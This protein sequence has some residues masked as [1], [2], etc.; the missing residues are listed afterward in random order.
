LHKR[1][2]KLC[3]S[4]ATEDFRGVESNTNLIEC[5]LQTLSRLRIFGTDLDKVFYRFWYF[6][7]VTEPCK[8][9][10]LCR[11]GC[12]CPAHGNSAGIEKKA[13]QKNS[14]GY[15]HV[16]REHIWVIVWQWRVSPV[17]QLFH[18]LG[19]FS[20]PEPKGNELRSPNLKVSNREGRLFCTRYTIP[21][22]LR[23]V[24]APFRIQY[25]WRSDDQVCDIPE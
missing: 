22:I 11:S 15:L 20:G 17:D 24:A 9:F 2:Y 18:F 13:Y 23:M 10:L 16:C 8:H 1:F 12:E 4:R 5:V 25:R 19:Y 6:T 3:S 7:L 21:N 14:D